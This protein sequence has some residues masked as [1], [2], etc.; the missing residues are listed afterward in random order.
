MLLLCEQLQE[1]Y[2]NQPEYI[3]SYA[4]EL[5]ILTGM[6]V[7]EIAALTWDCIS[8]DGILINKSAKYNRKTNAYLLMKPRTKKNV[9]FQCVMKSQNCWLK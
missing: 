6:R 3:P 1:D 9:C 8:E 2:K 5:A 7:G 4:V